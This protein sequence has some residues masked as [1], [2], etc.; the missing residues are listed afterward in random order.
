MNRRSFLKK[1]AAVA[2]FG[3]T[4]PMAMLARIA[5]AHAADP[6]SRNL[7]VIRLHGAFDSLQGINPWS[8]ILPAK[9]DLFT[10]YNPFEVGSV[11]D[12]KTMI[13]NADGTR[14]NL[15]PSAHALARHA[16]KMAIVN[17]IWVGPV[18]LGHPFAVQHMTSGRTQERAPHLAASVSN[19]RSGADQFLVINGPIERGEFK[20]KVLQTINLKNGLAVSNDGGPKTFVDAY[21]RR[22]SHL[23]GHRSFSKNRE[24]IEKFNSIL[25]DLKPA[26]TTN[27][28]SSG[29]ITPALQTF[30]ETEMDDV[31]AVGALAAGLSTVVQLD[32]Q[33]GDGGSPDNHVLYE[34]I[35]P[36]AQR[37]RWDRL[38]RLLDR[39]EKY[40]LMNN[41]LVLVLTEFSRTP[42]MNTNLGKDHNYSDNSA[43]LIGAGI[44]GGTT[45]GGHRSFGITDLRKEAQLTGDFIDFGDATGEIYRP[46]DNGA[47]PPGLDSIPKGID[48][49]R[50]ADLIRTAMEIVSP[51]IGDSLGRD[52][53]VIPRIVRG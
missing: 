40:N 41:T 5:Q 42:A 1:A 38:G 39:L 28:N 44:N 50:P 45:V 51:S 35:H 24:G 33:Q 25:K 4:V 19:A 37:N 3:G 15:G 11:G 21:S 20:L 31:A 48:L 32:W 13:R 26:V 7:V 10:T 30:G 6:F 53:K 16:K 23:E 29:G 36:M 14:I 27:S 2:S 9:Q 8:E 34:E 12:Y 17:G 43:I 18:D 52:A 49:I 47:K 22:A 46:R